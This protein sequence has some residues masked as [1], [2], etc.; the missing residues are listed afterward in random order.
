M[1]I[2]GIVLLLAGVALVAAE[3]HVGWG[4][5]GAAGVTTAV[6]G[7]ALLLAGGGAG[8]API[9]GVCLAVGLSGAG[10]L[11]GLV[12]KVAASRRVPA[13]SGTARL[14]GHLGVMRGEHVLVGG[15][16][17]RAA[18]S[19]LSDGPLHPGERV[20]VDGASGLT[21]RV[22]RAEEWELIA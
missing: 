21:L 6:L 16:L 13:R 7:A 8:W 2:A 9:L 14:V 11:T 17:W 19:P 18:P 3:V 12:R 10:L 15:A 4:P 20:V 1:L 5:I 22:R